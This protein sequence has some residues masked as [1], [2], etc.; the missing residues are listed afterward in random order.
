L[1]NYSEMCVLVLWPL[2]IRG[3]PAS[4]THRFLLSKYYLMFLCVGVCAPLEYVSTYVP[5]YLEKCICSGVCAPFF[6]PS[7][8]Q[9]N[10][11]DINCF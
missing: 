10:T 11:F 1:F 2:E 4:V 3:S 7:H 6:M 8:I 9:L 5:S